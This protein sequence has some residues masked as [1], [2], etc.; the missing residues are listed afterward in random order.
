MNGCMAWK[1]HDLTAVDISSL[2]ITF[3]HSKSGAD[4]ISRKD[5]HEI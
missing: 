2:N 3:F 5:S 1:Y 4:D